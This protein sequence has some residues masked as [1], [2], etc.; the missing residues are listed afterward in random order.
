MR[1]SSR[2]FNSYGMLIASHKFYN[3][4][5]ELIILLLVL[6]FVPQRVLGRGPHLLL[7]NLSYVIKCCLV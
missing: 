1:F 5:C 3:E 7:S 4:V 6:S 2:Y